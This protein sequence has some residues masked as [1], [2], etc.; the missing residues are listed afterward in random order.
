MVRIKGE[1]KGGEVSWVRGPGCNQ[2]QYQWGKE[3]PPYRNH[4][5]SGVSFLSN[6]LPVLALGSPG[7]TGMQVRATDQWYLLSNS[8]LLL[9]KEH[10]GRAWV[11]QLSVTEEHQG[12]VKR[13]CLTRVQSQLPQSKSE[14]EIPGAGA[15]ALPGGKR[16]G[17]PSPLRSTRSLGR[18]HVWKPLPHHGTIARVHG[19][20]Q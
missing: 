4:L 11:R 1:L 15:R 2:S 12:R 10:F 3:S 6:L 19:R 9:Q 5:L 14:M 8:G 20:L 13:S 7:W 18:G 17:L 16:E